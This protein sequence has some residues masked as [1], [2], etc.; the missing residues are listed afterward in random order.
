MKV[1]WP[2]G[3]LKRITVVA[4]CSVDV[5]LADFNDPRG[6]SGLKIGKVRPTI[7]VQRTTT[8]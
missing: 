8:T 7:G 5:V 2:S 6:G 4:H 1:R 3:T